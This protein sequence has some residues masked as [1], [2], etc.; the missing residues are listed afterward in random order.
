MQ[1]CEIG[2]DTTLESVI[3]DKDV[4]ISDGRKLKGE[5]NYLLVIEKGMVI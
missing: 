1:K 3:C 2:S 4:I 5:R